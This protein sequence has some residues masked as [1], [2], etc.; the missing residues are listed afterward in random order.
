MYA[1][2][3]VSCIYSLAFPKMNKFGKKNKSGRGW[4]RGL[5][6][7]PPATGHSS[8]SYTKPTGNG[9]PRRE[10]TLAATAGAGVR[11]D[12]HRG[13]LV[14]RERRQSSPAVAAVLSFCTE[15]PHSGVH[16]QSSEP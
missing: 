9:E 2:T 14:G 4:L 7:Q 5:G 10:G 8:T 13:C 16:T 15:G 12:G 1:T 3:I 6:T 11:G